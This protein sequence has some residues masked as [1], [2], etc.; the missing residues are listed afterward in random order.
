MLQQDLA[1]VSLRDFPHDSEAETSA[2]GA[3]G[4]KG[5]EE[6]I[7]NVV[8]NAKAVVFDG[9]RNAIEIGRAHV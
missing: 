8:R 7:S 9:D 5:L 4:R 1:A 3:S 6:V 2:F